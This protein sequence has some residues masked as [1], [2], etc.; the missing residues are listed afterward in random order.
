MTYLLISLMLSL[1]IVDIVT[2]AMIIMYRTTVLDPASIFPSIFCH[3]CTWNNK[4]HIYIV[5]KKRQFRMSFIYSTESK[6]L[7]LVHIQNML[8]Y[9]VLWYNLMF[10][11][12]LNGNL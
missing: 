1:A 7:L 12:F 8:N 4:A 9:I 2:I 6:L 10:K 11:I 5:R 3:L